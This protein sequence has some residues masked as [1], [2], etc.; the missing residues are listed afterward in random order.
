MTNEEYRKEFE[1]EQKTIRRAEDLGIMRSAFLTATMDIDLAIKHFNVDLESWLAADD[2]NF[3]H[4]FMG[5]QRH[6]NRETLLFE[7]CFLPRFSRQVV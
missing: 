1:L 7:D 3:A 5:I 6:V 2:E 4:D